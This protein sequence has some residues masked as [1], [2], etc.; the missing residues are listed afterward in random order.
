MQCDV[1]DKMGGK[2]LGE[3]EFFQAPIDDNTR[4][5]WVCVLKHKDE[6]L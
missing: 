6:V 2:S 4:Y 1:F 5:E 3:S